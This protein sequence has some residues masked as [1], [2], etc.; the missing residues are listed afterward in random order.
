MLM[1]TGFP[2]QQSFPGSAWGCSTHSAAQLPGC[3]RTRD[4]AGSSRLLSADTTT[5]GTALSSAGI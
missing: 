2:A 4:P 3:L 1:K 5:P